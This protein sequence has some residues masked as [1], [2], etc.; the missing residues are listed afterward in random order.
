MRYFIYCR[1]S[2]EAEDRQVLSLESQRTEVERLLSARPDI[3]VVGVFEESKSAK[4]PGRPEFTRMMGCIQQGQAEGIIAWHPDRLAR[5]AVDGG[6][7]IHLLD[8]GCLKDLLFNSYTFENNAQGKF[9]LGIMLSQSKYYSD[10]LSANVKRGMRTKLEKGWKPNLAPIGYKNCPETKTIVPDGKHFDAVRS[11]FDLVLSGNYSPAQVHRIVCND[12]NY[13]TPLRKH[14]GGKHPAVSTVYKILTNPFYTGQI[15]WKGKLY[16]GNHI[17]VLSKADFR[18]VQRLI[19]K[20]DPV[21]AQTKIFPYTCLLRCGVCGKSIT[22]EHKTK[23]SGREYTYYHCTRKHSTPVCTEPSLEVRQLEP[24]IEAFFDR[25]SILPAAFDWFVNTVKGNALDFAHQ[26][27][28][29]HRER[30]EAV[31]SLKGQLDALTDLRLR[32]ILSDEEFTTKRQSLQQEL[33]IAQEKLEKQTTQDI[34]LEPSLILSFFLLRAKNWFRSADADTKRKLLKI[35]SSNPTL[36]ARKVLLEAKKPFNEVLLLA[37]SSRLCGQTGDV[38]TTNS[39]NCTMS[40]K[41]IK[42]LEAFLVDEETRSLAMQAKYLILE[43]DHEAWAQFQASFDTNPQRT[44]TAQ[45]SR[46][47]S[48]V[49]RLAS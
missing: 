43:I 30:E 10:N 29:M 45:A 44:D 2:T 11:M 39:Q 16:P 41:Q 19:G 20:A 18:K 6:H 47:P 28:E 25:V 7:I 38:G 9:M 26:S 5:N 22:A 21:K 1:K 49:L 15:R 46:S 23:P 37:Q 33:E 13:K 32:D 35:L 4:A 34:T 42:R 36:K 40:A 24:Q 14:T 12:W 3:E 8:Q 48:A 31:Q 17:P 27:Q